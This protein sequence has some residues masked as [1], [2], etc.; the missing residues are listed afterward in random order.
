M[1]ARAL[2]I[3]PGEMAFLQD[4]DGLLLF[5]FWGTLWGQL[6]TN[7]LVANG[8]LAEFVNE[9][10]LTVRPAFDELPEWDDAFG[11]RVLKR[12][13]GTLSERLEM[14]RFHKLLPR[15]VGQTAVVALLNPEGLRRIYRATTL[16]SGV[17]VREQLLLLAD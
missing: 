2:N 16:I 10:C 7:L 15:N 13:G 6:L 11:E 17:R 8:F 12:A 9:Y 1:V 3:Q 14:G 4:G 5:H